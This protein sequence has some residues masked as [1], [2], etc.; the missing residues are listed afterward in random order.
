MRMVM[1]MQGSSSR[2]MGGEGPR[3]CL[4]ARVGWACSLHTEGASAFAALS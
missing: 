3:R 4:Q 1:V 2:V